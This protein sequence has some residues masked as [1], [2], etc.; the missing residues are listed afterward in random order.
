MA[1][2]G[3]S[4]FV[5]LQKPEDNIGQSL[6]Y[7]GGLKA[8]EREAD[9]GRA[10]RAQVRREE[11]A[12]E[13][14]KEYGFK[15]DDFVSKVTGFDTYDQIKAD[16]ASQVSD[17]Y[18][19]LYRKAN[20]AMTSGNIQDRRKY[21][22]Q[23]MRLKGAFK[24]V[25][26]ADELIGKRFSESMKMAQEGKMSGVDSDTWDAEMQAIAK[27]M[28]YQIVVG[29]NGSPE[30]IGLKT[31]QDGSQEPFR[32][33]FSDIVNGTW[34]PYQKQ[35]VAGKGGLVDNILFNLGKKTVDNRTGVLITT[36][37]QWDKER[38]MASKGHIDS[39]LA[40][41]EVMADLYHQMV[42]STSRKRKDFTEEEKDKVAKKMM[43]LIEGGYSTESKTTVD[44]R[45]QALA[46]TIRDNR[47]RRAIA[48][49]GLKNRLA[50][51]QGK[52]LSKVEQVDLANRS[53][54]V[55]AYGLTKRI[56]E[57]QEKN[58]NITDRQLL[59]DPEIKKMRD[60]LGIDL[61][62]RG[63]LFGRSTFGRGEGKIK[64]G[65]DTYD[66]KDKSKIA[67]AVADELGFI[68][69]GR[70]VEDDFKEIGGYD[71]LYDKDMI[72]IIR[73]TGK[74]TTRESSSTS[75]SGSYSHDDLLD[76]YGI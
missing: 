54:S 59:E 37:Q 20:E 67:Q 4:A 30:V 19:D 69:D 65:K 9:K 43:F 36:N 42:D 15:Y 47:E 60:V 11:Q 8:Q 29:S 17:Q 25:Q 18:V 61:S 2:G 33:K 16:Y 7:W 70:V 73:G 28:N 45:E 5:R 72:N 50:E 39:L 26:Q 53:K 34:R 32:I 74:T 1:Q 62:D 64:I 71:G 52:S 63:F 38:E 31:L 24:Q 56:G 46:E 12:K 58:P 14:D 40:S 57:L 44:T 6:Q 55:I 49:E 76:K 68:Y 3:G 10:E 27:D 35:Q 75:S 41:D 13:W 21:E 51:A 23:M 66:I 22:S 48:R